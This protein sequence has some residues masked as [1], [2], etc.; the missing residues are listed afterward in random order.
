MNTSLL[1]TLCY[2]LAIA[3][4]TSLFIYGLSFG[5]IVTVFYTNRCFVSTTLRIAETRPGKR[6]EHHYSRLG[7]STSH[8][9]VQQGWR[10][11]RALA[12]HQCGPD[13]IPGL[14][15]ISG[16]SLLVLYSA[17][18]SFS[19]GTP[20][21]PSPQKLEFDLIWFDLCWVDLNCFDLISGYP[22]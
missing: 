11:V 13:S 6:R 5:R 10:S 8:N 16:L 3:F 4:R 7:I 1:R 9:S 22:R 19:T 20:V 2:V 21:F 14:G 15:V 17:P 12:F 18:R